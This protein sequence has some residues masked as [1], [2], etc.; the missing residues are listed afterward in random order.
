[1]T[2]AV[3]AGLAAGCATAAAALLLVSAAAAQGLTAEEIARGKYIFGAMTGCGCHTMKDG[4]LN[5]GGYKFEMPFGTV[6]SPNITP[7][8]E[9]GIGSWTDEQLIAGMSEGRRPKGERM[10]PIHPY[11][12]FNG[13]AAQDLRALVA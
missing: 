13:M 3:R 9:T 2:R 1:M 12:S 4:L 11:A 8:R 7:D 6:Y 5:A 10:I